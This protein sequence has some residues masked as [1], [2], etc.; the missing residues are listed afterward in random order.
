MERTHRPD[1]RGP[2][3]GSRV[4][5]ILVVMERTHRPQTVGRV[6]PGSRGVSILVVMERTHR[7]DHGLSGRW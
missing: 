6:R 1:L 5:S 3:D 7:P 2:G 4:V